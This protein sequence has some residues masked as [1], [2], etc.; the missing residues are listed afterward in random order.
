ML[1]SP[2][3]ISLAQVNSIPVNPFEARGIPPQIVMVYAG[4]EYHGK[5]IRYITNYTSP[6]TGNSPTLGESLI[7]PTNISSST[8]PNTNMISVKRNA[9]VSFLIKDNGSSL[10]KSQP[11]SIS[12]TAYDVKGKPL[13]LLNTTEKSKTSSVVADLDPGQ[14][15]I[16]SVAIWLPQQ[17]D[18]T[19]TG[20]VSYGYRINVVS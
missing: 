18:K 20:F 4:K 17:G 6:N 5:L 19:K 1:T 15:N 10:A 13:K 14:Y 12:V 8:A 9:L 3:I 7:T 16:L 2:F 11:N